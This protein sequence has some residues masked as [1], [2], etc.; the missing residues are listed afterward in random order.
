MS[1]AATR[2]RVGYEED[3][4]AWADDQARLIRAGDFAALDL[5]HLAEEIEGLSI[6]E[7]RELRSRLNSSSSAPYQVAIPAGVSQSQ[8]VE[9][10]PDPTR[11]R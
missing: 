8:L 5:E 11:E 10:N 4:S 2:N 7:R 1:E 9:D 6:S 3:F